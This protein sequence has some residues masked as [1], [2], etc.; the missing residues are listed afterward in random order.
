MKVIGV[1]LGGGTG[2]RLKPLT[3]RRAKPAVPLAGQYRLV[4]VPISNCTNSNIHKIYLLTQYQSASLHHHIQSA[5]RFDQFS[6]GF[7]QLLAA[8]QKPSPISIRSRMG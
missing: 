8:E 4:D 5:Y 7:V 3:V 2:S 1:V 6:K